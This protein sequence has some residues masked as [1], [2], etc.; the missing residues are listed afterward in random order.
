MTSNLRSL[1]IDEADRILEI[2]FE[3]DLKEIISILPG[4]NFILFKNYLFNSIYNTICRLVIF[5]QFLE[6]R[7]TMLFSATN[8]KKTEDLAKLAIKKEPVYVEI[9]DNINKA[10]VDGLVQGNYYILKEQPF[11]NIIILQQCSPNF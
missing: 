9:Q 2:G 6:K 8:T 7:Q 3:E 11:Q 4:L 1:I 5:F 10:T